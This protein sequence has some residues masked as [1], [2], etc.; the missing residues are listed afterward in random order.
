MT[1]DPWPK[2]ATEIDD[3]EGDRQLLLLAIAELALRRPGFDWTLRR[4]AGRLQG[5]GE[6]D[7]FKQTSANIVRPETNAVVRK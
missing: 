2:P 7:A 3:D 6:F 1:R 5:T 4:L